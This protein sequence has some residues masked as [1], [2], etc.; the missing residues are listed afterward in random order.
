MMDAKPDWSQIR[1]S[2]SGHIQP[3]YGSSP[4]EELLQTIQSL[5][6]EL[7]NIRKWLE[8]CKARRDSFAKHAIEARSDLRRSEAALREYL[9][10]DFMTDGVFPHP[11]SDIARRYFEDK[12]N[13]EC[14]GG[15]RT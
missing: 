12:K 1:I 10:S 3:A 7:V 6:I 9:N 13:R 5:E 2:P 4:I 14:A 15:R 8:E 11:I